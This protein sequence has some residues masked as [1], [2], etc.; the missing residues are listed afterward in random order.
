MNVKDQVQVIRALLTDVN[1]R[2]AEIEAK[3]ADLHAERRGLE[4]SL[5][6]LTAEAAREDE[7]VQQ[8]RQLDSESA[9]LP[10][11]QLPR[12]VSRAE[13]WRLLSKT[14]AVKRVLENATTP[15]APADVVDV[16]NSVGLPQDDSESV[17]GTL[18]HLK[19]KGEATFVG[20]SQWVLVGSDVHRRLLRREKGDPT[21][22]DADVASA[23]TEATSVPVHSIM[24]GGGANGGTADRDHDD[25][26]SSRANHRVHGHG[27]SVVGGT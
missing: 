24:N 16:L 6:R 14:D 5:A 17:R 18:A 22:E 8:S 7:T 21:S 15:M 27:A 11:R 13:G 12:F 3:L 26:S 25:T 23:D 9:S 4:L 20:R 19:K 1:T 2:A 10:S